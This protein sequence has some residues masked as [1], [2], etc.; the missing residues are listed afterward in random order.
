MEFLYEKVAYLKGLADGLDIDESTKEGRLLI[1]II[2]ILEDFA[3]AIV[4]LDE[5]AEE[6]TE[7]VEAMDED[8]AN[9]EDDFYEDDIY[10]DEDDEN[11]EVDFVEIECPNCHEDVYIDEDLLYEDDVD[12]VCPRCHEIV[13]FDEME[14]Y[15]HDDDDEDE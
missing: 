11:D 13:D 7:Y 1:S 5:D 6:I 8:L 4:E 3:D 12:V 2:D 10:E 15:H 14:E 9:V